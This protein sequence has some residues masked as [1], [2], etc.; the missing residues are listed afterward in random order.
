[1]ITAFLL[2]RGGQKGKVRPKNSSVVLRSKKAKNLTHRPKLYFLE[3]AAKLPAA[4]TSRTESAETA[5]GALPALEVIL[6]SSSL[7]FLKTLLV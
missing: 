6:S 5:E 2:K 4:G 1:L 7:I 3:M